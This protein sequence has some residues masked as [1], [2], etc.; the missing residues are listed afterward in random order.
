MTAI[1]TSTE[2]VLRTYTRNGHAPK[3]ARM[4]ARRQLQDWHMADFAADLELIASE[5]VTNA[6]QYSAGHMVAVQLRRYPRRVTI[7]VWDGNDREFP[8]LSPAGFDEES[9]RG[10]V[11]V[12]TL[13]ARWGYDVDEVNGGKVVWATVVR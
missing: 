11:L 2:A 12:G 8:V 5:L 4:F 13:S 7:Q 1:M 6:V 10:L 3:F 9:G